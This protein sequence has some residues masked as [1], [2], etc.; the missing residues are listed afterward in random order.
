MAAAF[1]KL[2]LDRRATL[3]TITEAP[4]PLQPIDL[5]DD[6]TV[7]EALDVAVRVGE[8]LLGLP[9]QLVLVTHDLDLAAQCD[10]ALVV[11]EGR[12]AFDGP[13]SSAVDHYRMLVS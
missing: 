5:T 13:A 2:V 1:G 7:A 4:A 9:Q 10:R 3:D 12:V 6:A 11:H 8:V